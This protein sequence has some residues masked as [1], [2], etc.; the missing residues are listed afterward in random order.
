MT[1]WMLG[2]TLLVLIG[3]PANA[4]AQDCGVLLRDGIFDHDAK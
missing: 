1:R 4:P 2:V 3:T